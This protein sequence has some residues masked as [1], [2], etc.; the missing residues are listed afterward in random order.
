MAGDDVEERHG[1]DLRDAWREEYP[2]F[3]SEVRPLPGAA[4]LVRGAVGDGDRVAL[5]SSGDP[6]FAREAVDL[7]GSVTRSRC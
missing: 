2:K 7:L 3:R 6:Q 4:D 1:D 5:A